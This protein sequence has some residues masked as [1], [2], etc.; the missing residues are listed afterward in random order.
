MAEVGRV[1]M[2]TQEYLE[3][4]ETLDIKIQQRKK[5]LYQIRINMYSLKQLGM[6]DRVKSSNRE[7]QLEEKIDDIQKIEKE[8]RN[9]IKS[10]VKKRHKIIREIQ[11]MHNPKYI[12]I[13]FKKY[14]EYKKMD[15]IRTE[16]SITYESAKKLHQRALKEFKKCT[17]NVP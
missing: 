8:T 2:S 1:Q 4:I 14:V 17:P 13:L 16:M 12:D 15:E 5:E 11:V 10:M 6:S 9:M 7:Y 3:Q